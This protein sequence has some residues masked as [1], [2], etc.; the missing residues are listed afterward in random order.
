MARDLSLLHPQMIPLVQDWQ[1]KLPFTVLIY[2]TAR[3]AWEQAL[4][5]AQGRTADEIASGV[6]R[7]RGLNLMREADLLAKQTPRPG[8]RATKALPGLSFHQSH[9]LE[10]KW[11]ALAIDFVPTIGGKP[12]WGAEEM[13]EEAGQIAEAV[14][15]TWS[16]RWVSF[17]ETCHCQWDKAGTIKIIPLA[18]GAYK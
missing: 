14:G 16:G 17:K 13:Y 11:G 1:A 15:L 6:A 5:Y 18:Q 7:L 10:G 9:W 12:L 3:E 2:Q 8:R 4:V